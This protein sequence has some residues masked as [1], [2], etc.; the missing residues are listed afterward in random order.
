LVPEARGWNSLRPAATVL[1]RETAHGEDMRAAILINVFGASLLMTAVSMG[2]Q[3]P[4]AATR[5]QTA[6]SLE[7][8][9]RVEEAESAWRSLLALEPKSAEAYAHLGLLEAHQEHFKEAIA[10]Y[11]K[12]LA[13]NPQNQ[14][15]RIN[16]GLSLFKAG[17]PKEMIQLFEPMLKEMPAAAQQRPRLVALVGLAHYGLGNYAAAVPYLREAVTYDAQN[18]QFR[19][20]V[21]HSCLWSKQFQ[22]VLDEYREI[23][24][25]NPNAAE[26]FMLAGEAYDELKDDTNALAQF[27]AA[28]NA[29][30]KLPDVHFGYGYLLWRLKHF[31]E[32]S[33]EFRAEL[34]NN[35]DHVLALTYLGDVEVHLQRNDEAA[36]YLERAI[37]LDPSSALAH[38]DLGVV[39]ESQGRK[40]DALREFQTSAKLNP[41][42]E[43]IHWRLGRLYQSMGRKE[44]AKAELEK[45]RSLQR[46]QDVPL[47]DKINKPLPGSNR[48]SG[49]AAPN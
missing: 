8:Q 41:N 42:D 38:L 18:L 1:S 35:P 31:D 12:A 17:E 2:Q 47:V 39:F 4:S 45:T 21:A 10:D 28:V 23:I 49:G 33:A 9:G 25:I 16:L 44:E 46:L 22:C 26:A 40:D 32:A 5:R 34:A 37:Q 7:Q 30:P 27:K 24:T 13:I 3:A 14:N 43:N 36:P 48:K 19:L 20:M 11:R 6:L 29:D 15:V